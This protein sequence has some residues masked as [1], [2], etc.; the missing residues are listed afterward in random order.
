MEKHYV[1]TI[2]SPV[3]NLVLV[4]DDDYLTGVLFE[5]VSK[6]PLAK[7]SVLK[8]TPNSILRET[9][10]QLEAYFAGDLI[11]FTLKIKPPGTDFQKKAWSA[12]CEIPYGTSISYA[13]QALRIGSPKALRAIGGANGQ[14]PIA[15]VIPCHRVIGKS[16]QLTGFGGGMPIKQYLLDL[17]S[18]VLAA[19]QSAQH[20]KKLQP[21][22]FNQSFLG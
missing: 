5:H 21:L 9:Q 20:F 19:S 8:N 4:A 6:K 1:H 2:P 15:I 12:L 18:N 3:G 17:E 13:E 22:E 14:N 7:I 11:D 10:Q 16:G